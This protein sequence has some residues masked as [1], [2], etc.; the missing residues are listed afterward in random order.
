[1]TR[2]GLLRNPPFGR[3]FSAFCQQQD[4]CAVHRL[5]PA[6]ICCSLACPAI[7]ATRQMSPAQPLRACPRRDTRCPEICTDT[8]KPFFNTLLT[9]PT[10]GDIVSCICWRLRMLRRCKAENLNRATTGYTA[11]PMGAMVTALTATLKRLSRTPGERAFL[12]HIKE[13]LNCTVRS[14][15]PTVSSSQNTKEL[16][17]GVAGSR[18]VDRSDN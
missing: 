7:G 8:I 9:R 5:E 2:S 14:D 6:C 10:D 13:S 12:D 16:K 15:P 11:A 17:Y 3:V 1:M 18:V 4:G